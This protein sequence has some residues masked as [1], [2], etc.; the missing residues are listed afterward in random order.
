M[1]S[2]SANAPATQA[3]RPER[4]PKNRQIDGADRPTQIVAVI[5]VGND[6]AELARVVSQMSEDRE[7][8]ER[9]HQ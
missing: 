8:D 6:P 4:L 5:Y 7:P 3:P 2:R 9:G 1:Q